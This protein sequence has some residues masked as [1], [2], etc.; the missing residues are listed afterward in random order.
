MPDPPEFEFEP[1]PPP[2]PKAPEVHEDAANVDLDK[3]PRCPE[4]GYALHGLTR[5]LCPE[6]GTVFRPSDVS[7]RPE[8]VALRRGDRRAR[9]MA[10]SGAA[11][12]V[13]GIV[14]AMYAFHNHVAVGGLLLGPLIGGTAACLLYKLANEDEL[15]GTLLFLGICWAL[16]GGYFAVVL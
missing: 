10:W 15:H 7:T 11:L 14:L 16:L 12:L 3:L 6:C 13:C 4:C 9:R 1:L 5:N 2:L 8:Q